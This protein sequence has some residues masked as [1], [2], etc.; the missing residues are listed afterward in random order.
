MSISID[1]KVTKLC[2]DA[3][4]TQHNK[5]RICGKQPLIFNRLNNTYCFEHTCRICHGYKEINKDECGKCICKC[6]HCNKY[7]SFTVNNGMISR[8]LYCD[9]H[10]FFGKC[11]YYIRKNI[12]GI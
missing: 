2:C 9:E 1:I 8:N 10:I 5:L 11:I 12:Y 4:V 3:F 6:K 7:V